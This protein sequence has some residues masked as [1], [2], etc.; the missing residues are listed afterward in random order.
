MAGG[1]GTR[2]RGSRAH[3]LAF[4]RVRGTDPLLAQGASQATKL[5]QAL[6]NEKII[7]RDGT[8]TVRLRAGSTIPNWLPQTP[9]LT[10]LASVMQAGLEQADAGAST[11]PAVEKVPTGKAKRS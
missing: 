3:A 10:R 7:T 1:R 2:P 4:E 6:E 8:G 11:T 5:L 9:T